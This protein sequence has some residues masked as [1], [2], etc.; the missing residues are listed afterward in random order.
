MAFEHKESEVNKL[1]RL[2]AA[3]RKAEE[4]LQRK[5]DTRVAARDQVQEWKIPCKNNQH[6]VE[7]SIRMT[8]QRQPK[9]ART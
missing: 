7:M 2:L 8:Y 4:A 3:A 6:H 5:Q 9:V 1:T